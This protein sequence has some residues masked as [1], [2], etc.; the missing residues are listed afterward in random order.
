[1]YL[2]KIFSFIKNF[3]KRVDFSWIFFATPSTPHFHHGPS[4]FW[5]LTRVQLWVTST[6]NTFR[7]SQLDDSEASLTEA[8][9]S[10]GAYD[11][12]VHRLIDHADLP[13]ETIFGCVLTIPGTSYRVREESIYRHRG[14]SKSRHISLYFFYKCP[15]PF[16]VKLKF[17]FPKVII[18]YISSS[19]WFQPLTSWTSYFNHDSFLL[20]HD[21]FINLGFFTS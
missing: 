10:H 6:T 19:I 16:S 20:H 2:P 21:P 9:Q 12:V 13:S 5:F 17:S 8:E 14:G 18:A 15:N 7:S 1:M 3:Y 11:I 4:P